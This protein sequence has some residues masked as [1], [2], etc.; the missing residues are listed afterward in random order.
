[1]KERTRRRWI[2]LVTTLIVVMGVLLVALPQADVVRLAI[3][4]S[5]PD[6]DGSYSEMLIKVPAGGRIKTI[7][8]RGNSEALAD[9]DKFGVILINGEPVELADFKNMPDCKGEE[10]DGF[11]NKALPV[12]IKKLRQRSDLTVSCKE[13]APFIKHGDL[14][15][16]VEL[17]GDS[18]SVK[19]W[20]DIY[21]LR[22]VAADGKPVTPAPLPAENKKAP[23]ASTAGAE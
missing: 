10:K 2:Y 1:M 5:P 18:E 20:R 15:V 4:V 8:L 9:S 17:E 16:V 3:V 7:Y 12:K 13:L 21:K 19:D 23:A 22:L 14:E 11:A 6:A